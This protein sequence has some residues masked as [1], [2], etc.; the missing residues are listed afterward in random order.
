MIFPAFRKPA[1]DLEYI[2]HTLWAE[3]RDEDCNPVAA[4][5]TAAA[6]DDDDQSIASGDIFVDP[7]GQYLFN[8]SICHN[9]LPVP[10]ISNSTG[11]M[12]KI[13]RGSA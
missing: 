10:V 5:T 13:Q 2:D 3:E 8:S 7:R 1:T 12:N 11:T 6:D 9:Y 4:A